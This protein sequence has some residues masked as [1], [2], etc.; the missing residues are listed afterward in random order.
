MVNNKFRILI[1][2][3]VGYRGRRWEVCNKYVLS[4][5]LFYSLYLVNIFNTGRTSFKTLEPKACWVTVKDSVFHLP[6]L[7]LLSLW[8]FELDKP[9]KLMIPLILF[10]EGQKVTLFSL[11]SSPPVPHWYSE[12]PSFSLK[13]FQFYNILI[14]T[15]PFQGLPELVFLEREKQKERERPFII[16][17]AW[18]GAWFYFTQS[19]SSH[20]RHHSKERKK[21]QFCY[22]ASCCLV[23]GT[24]GR[25]LPTTLRGCQMC[26]AF[27]SMPRTEQLL[28]WQYSSFFLEHF[29]SG[30]MGLDSMPFLED[31][32]DTTA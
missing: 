28:Q 30:L 31:F 11:L 9:I 7:I 16:S 22:E 1:T 19:F 13:S 26:W 17:A 23:L 8:R 25:Y 2:F 20:R 14:L 27:R 4:L 18:G 32:I 3:G 6:P 10:L 12:K 15:P 29:T 24:S 5:V 21:K